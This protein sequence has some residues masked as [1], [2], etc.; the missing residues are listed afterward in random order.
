M[1]VCS[2]SYETSLS[3]KRSGSSQVRLERPDV[4]Q[5]DRARGF[6]GLQTKQ[7][8]AHARMIKER[9]IGGLAPRRTSLKKVKGDNVPTKPSLVFAQQAGRFHGCEI[10]RKCRDAC[11]TTYFLLSS[12][13]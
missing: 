3:L 6:R 1:A 2:A 7:V 10:A 5:G 9:P 4:G 13:D 11:E 8:Q 12:P